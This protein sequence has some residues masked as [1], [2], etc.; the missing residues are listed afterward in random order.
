MSSTI[1]STSFNSSSATS[2]TDIDVESSDDILVRIA[3]TIH[4]ELKEFYGYQTVF[5]SF[6]KNWSKLSSQVD[7]LRNSISNHSTFVV[8]V[9]NQVDIY[10]NAYE[11]TPTKKVE[12]TTEEGKEYIRDRIE[13]VLNKFIQEINEINVSQNQNVLRLTDELE[14][15]FNCISPDEIVKK[16]G[17]DQLFSISELHLRD[18]ERK[19]N[20][21][22]A[23]I[24]EDQFNGKKK[25]KFLDTRGTSAASTPAS[26]TRSVII[27]C[28]QFVVRIVRRIS[29]RCILSLFCCCG[30]FF[31]ILPK[32][33]RPPL[34]K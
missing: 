27:K 26:N 20:E 30:L 2:Y 4:I 32:R 23:S 28:R 25:R 18:S 15:K 5:N 9:N 21:F 33:D 11:Q 13:R 24:R 29:L 22:A 19:I 17:E 8:D 10:I 16:Y 6:I 7:R 3:K 14:T 34:M 31:W 1:V 12:M